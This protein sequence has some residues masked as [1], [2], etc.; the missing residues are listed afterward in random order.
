MIMLILVVGAM[1]GRGP[2]GG[3]V[4]PGTD[5]VSGRPEGQPASGA[6]LQDPPGGGGGVAAAPEVPTP[7]PQP[8]PGLPHPQHL[9]P[10]HG[11]LAGTAGG[12]AR[13]TRLPV[14]RTSDQV[15]MVTG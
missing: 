11:R 2:Q 9:Q 7:G 6:V 14:S 1:T 13:S 10:G 15:T 8:G 12:N 5:L 3:A 4:G